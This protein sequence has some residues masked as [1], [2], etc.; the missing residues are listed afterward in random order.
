[1][2]ILLVEEEV[3]AAQYLRKGLVESGFAVD[4]MRVRFRGIHPAAPGRIRFAGLRRSAR[5]GPH[6]G[7]SLGQPAPAGAVPGRPQ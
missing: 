1:M 5:H 2:R 7:D 6:V 3:E 4:V